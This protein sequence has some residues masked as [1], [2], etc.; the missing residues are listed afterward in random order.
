MQLL[1]YANRFFT[2]WVLR[3]L[4]NF[5]IEIKDPLLD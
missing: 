3:P 4:S 2:D 1:I 5:K